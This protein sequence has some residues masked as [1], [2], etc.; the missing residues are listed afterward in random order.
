MKNKK[1][2]YSTKWIAYTAMLTALVVATGYIPGIPVLTGKIY[3]CDFAIYTAAYLMDPLSAMIV[4]GIGT[5]FFDLFGINGTAY[6]ALPS[7]IIH[8]IQGFAAS[9]IFTLLKSH[10]AKN[11]GNKKEGIVAVISSILPALWVIFGYFVKRITVESAAPE[12]AIMKMPA[13]ILQETIGIVVAVAICYAC[14]L[15]QQLIKAHLLP[16]F[17]KEIIE[18]PAQATDNQAQPEK[19]IAE[20][21]SEN[22]QPA[23]LS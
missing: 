3:W 18:K 2:F 22:T 23:E 6:N 1:A 11:A 16:D 13:N 14:R 8:G 15:K 17:R 5:T 9:L 21:Q 20:A 19:T 12:V 7:L 10:F 4:G